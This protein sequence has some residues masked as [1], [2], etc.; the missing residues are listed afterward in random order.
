[1]LFYFSEKKKKKSWQ[2]ENEFFYKIFLPSE[3]SIIQLRGTLVR[4]RKLVG[5]SRVGMCMHAKSL[6]S[7]LTLCN[8]MDC[9][10]R[11][12]FVHGILQARI[13]KWVAMPFPG[14][15]DRTQVSYV[16]CTGRWVL[17]HQCHLGSPRSFTEE[18]I[19]IFKITEI[20]MLTVMGIMNA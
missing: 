10:L 15:R 1:M 14:S 7:C 13:L 3:M 6:Q 11:D 8:R 2:V 20:G 5:V 17:H 9:S 19:C 16:S 12:S 18:Q 4:F